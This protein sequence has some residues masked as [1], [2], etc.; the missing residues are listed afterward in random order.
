VPNPGA[1][2]WSN[3]L[4]PQ[5]LGDS[6]KDPEHPVSATSLRP[7]ELSVFWVDKTGALTMSELD[8]AQHAWSFPSHVKDHNT[9]FAPLPGTEISVIS[10]ASDDLWLFWASG[11]GSVV[12]KR[13]APGHSGTDFGDDVVIQAASCAPQTPIAAVTLSSIPGSVSVLWVDVYG[14][15]WNSTLFPSAKYPGAT[16]WSEPVIVVDFPG[17]PPPGSRIAAVSTGPETI[18][19]F[20]FANDS[21]EGW[22]DGGDLVS[23]QYTIK[24]GWSLNGWLFRKE[25]TGSSPWT[26]PSAVSPADGDVA[27]FWEA[28]GG[29]IMT[30]YKFAADPIYPGQWF[31][32]FGLADGMMP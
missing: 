22:N 13:R 20:Y 32:P 5:P 26:Q 10:P 15:V 24:N 8:P 17:G 12:G 29:V 2:A 18:E 27:V 28:A 11:D 6:N 31:W 30:T 1:P 25:Y 14:R 7:G 19:L 9:P 4:F 23:A 16:T 21:S 3:W